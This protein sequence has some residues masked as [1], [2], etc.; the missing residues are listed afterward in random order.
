MTVD[1]SGPPGCAV[2]SETELPSMVEVIRT[3]HIEPHAGF[4]MSARA[5]LN[6]AYPDGAPDELNSYG[7]R[8]G[9]PAATILL[10]DGRRVIGHLAI[11]EAGS[12][13]KPCKSG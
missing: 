6:D 8:H 2:R 10:R 13:M 1:P 7:A 11:Y 4:A 5:L 12:G 3:G 9:I